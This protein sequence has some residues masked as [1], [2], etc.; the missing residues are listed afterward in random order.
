MIRLQNHSPSTLDIYLSIYLLTGHSSCKLQII[1][2]FDIAWFGDNWGSTF[3]K[4]YKMV[5]IV[6]SAPSLS[7]SLNTHMYKPELLWCVGHHIHRYVNALGVLYR[8]CQGH[9]DMCQRRQCPC[10]RLL[11]WTRPWWLA[12]HVGHPRE[13]QR[14]QPFVCLLGRPRNLPMWKEVK[15]SPAVLLKVQFVPPLWLRDEIHGP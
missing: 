1:V 15:C 8:S 7:S 3:C 10:S 2:K 11:V 6:S 12:P 14:R 4:Y 5:E 13:C 9:S